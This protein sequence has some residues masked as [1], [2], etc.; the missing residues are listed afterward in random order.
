MHCL[1]LCTFACFL[2]FMLWLS[3]TSGLAALKLRG[4]DSSDKN[5]PADETATKTAG[6]VSEETKDS[7]ESDKKKGGEDL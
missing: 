3:L 2:H 5:E 6:D 1:L 4:D 7:G